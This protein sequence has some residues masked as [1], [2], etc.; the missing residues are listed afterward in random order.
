MVGASDWRPDG[1][2]FCPRLSFG[3]GGPA[4]GSA[5]LSRRGAANGFYLNGAPSV[6]VGYPV[7]RPRLFSS[8]VAADAQAS[9]RQPPL[10]R[11]TLRRWRR[12]QAE[13]FDTAAIVE[14]IRNTAAG[15]TQTAN[16]LKGQVA[17]GSRSL[18][19]ATRQARFQR[20][21][22]AQIRDEHIA[23]PAACESLDNGQ[24]IAVGA[25][26][27]WIVATSLTSVANR[28]RGGWPGNPCLARRGSRG[29]EPTRLPPKPLLLGV[30]GRRR[31]LPAHGQADGGSV[32]P[33]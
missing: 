17:A 1:R 27:S 16:H 5:S 23:T 29:G 8:E 26:Q 30:G 21:P 2:Q 3:G 4:L 33:A 13:V 10:P 28:R 20:N 24:A 7:V 18:T 6:P 9:W 31:G 15:F 12:P 25:G 22:S 19:P 14:L 11:C 32:Q